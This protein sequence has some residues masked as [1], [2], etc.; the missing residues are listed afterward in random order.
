MPPKRWQAANHYKQKTM[1]PNLIKGITENV[2]YNYHNNIELAV[3]T[4]IFQ[5]TDSRNDRFRL[6]DKQFRRIFQ[7]C[8]SFFLF[9]YGEKARTLIG[10]YYDDS[11]SM[12]F[13][14]LAIWE[15]AQCLQSLIFAPVHANSSMNEF[16]KL[17]SFLNI[18]NVNRSNLKNKTHYRRKLFRSFLFASPYSWEF[19]QHIKLSKNCVTYNEENIENVLAEFFNVEKEENETDKSAMIDSI[20]RILKTI[21]SYM[22]GEKLFMPYR[23]QKDVYSY[24]YFHLTDFIELYQNNKALFYAYLDNSVDGKSTFMKKAFVYNYGLFII[25]S[26]DIVMSELDCYC[27]HKDRILDVLFL[28]NSILPNSVIKKIK[29]VYIEK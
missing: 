28:S 3:M 5:R 16:S 20:N 21:Y 24:Y 6:S 23:P 19:S 15:F 2:S 12:Y 4:A 10:K 9:E 27:K 25:S 11:E 8:P 7:I 13:N 29:F 26:P 18:I 17:Y 14:Y 22:V 1:K